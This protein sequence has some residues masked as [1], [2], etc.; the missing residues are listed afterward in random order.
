MPA[1]SRRNLLLG[2]ATTALPFPDSA[3]VASAAPLK[4]PQLTEREQYF[5]ASK[6]IETGVHDDALE[7]I[8]WLQEVPEDLAQLMSQYGTTD[9]NDT[10]LALTLFV[11]IDCLIDRVCGP[12]NAKQ[13]RIMK[14]ALRLSLNVQHQCSQLF[15]LSGH[16]R[17][18]YRRIV[19]RRLSRPA[20]AARAPREPPEALS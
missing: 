1:V 20:R 12:A 16:G 13:S 19:S 18:A 15:K 10:A 3:P 6:L 17:K 14:N 9:I 4:V 11:H 5:A 8:E 2:A 7:R